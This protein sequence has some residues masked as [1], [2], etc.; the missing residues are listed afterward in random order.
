MKYPIS[1][2]NFEKIVRGG[3][4]YVDKTDL[5]YDLAQEN[6]C[7][8]SRPR[9]FGKSLLLS[10]L[11]AYF[12][13]RKDLFKG[14]ALEKIEEESNT[15]Y[16]ARYGKW[17]EYPVLKIDFANGNY[18]EAGELTKKLDALLTGWENEFGKDP[19]QQTLGDRF[20]YVIE[21][22]KEKTGKPVVVL[23]DEYD[24]PLLD[25]MGDKLEEI[26]RNILKGFY[27]TFKAADASLRFVL[28]TGVTKFS[29]ISVF[30]GFNQPNYIS[31]D[32]HYDAICGIT[33]EELHRVF[34]EPIAEMAEEMECSVDEMKEM[35]KKQYDGYHFS[36]KLIDIYNP[37]S[38]INAFN[39]MNL[40]SYWYSSGTPGYLVKLMEGHHTNMQRMLEKQYEASYFVD[41][42][43]DVED[44]LAMLYQSGYLTIKSYDK[45]YRVYTLDYPNDEVRKGFIALTA[46]SYFG[47]TSLDD[48]NW[49]MNLDMMLRRCD[50]DGIRDAYTSFLA[51]IPYEANKD[52]RAKDFETHFQYT[53]YIINRLLSCYTILIEKQNSKDRSDIIIESDNDIYIFE[54]K[55]DGTAEE[56]LQQIEDR[57]YAL[58]YL[59]DSRPVHKI[60]VNISSE[61]RTVSDWRHN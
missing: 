18:N 8:L 40:G 47:K 6:V 34:A 54:F 24:K 22:A 17:T 32:R 14:L 7:F 20:K 42:R 58:P 21:K 49:L 26:N 41:Y 28:L 9:R 15:E 23:I 12:K 36:N 60:G 37:F 57:Q 56:T 2:Q 10:T 4:I 29:Q 55:L 3:Y 59:Q 46:N 61:T 39:K 31:M 48:G 43:A 38:I 30:S 27:G 16:T 11:E 19:A 33:E 35:L 44:P 51:S 53:F 5:I 52:E 45:R 13:G 50:L 1:V 25:V